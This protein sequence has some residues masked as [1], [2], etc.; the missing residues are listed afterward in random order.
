M[1]NHAVSHNEESKVAADGYRWFFFV[2]IL[3][4]LFSIFLAT[5]D[6]RLSESDGERKLGATLRELRTAQ[7]SLPSR[8]TDTRETLSFLHTESNGESANDESH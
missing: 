7:S 4:V 2:G 5:V 3:A 1:G 6:K 8:V